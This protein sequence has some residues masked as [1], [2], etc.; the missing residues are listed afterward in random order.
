[1]ATSLPVSQSNAAQP[2]TVGR[3]IAGLSDYYKMWINIRPQDAAQD[4][5]NPGSS[6]GSI[7][8]YGY[9]P[10]NFSID[11]SADWQNTFGG[12]N[13]GDISK[14][15]QVGLDVTG[16]NFQLRSMTRLSYSGPEHLSLQLPFIFVAETNAYQDVS[17][18]IQTLQ[19]MCAPRQIGDVLIPPGP[20]RINLS[21]KLSGETISVKIGGFLYLSNV[22]I[23]S[24]S[25]A[26]DTRFDSGGNCIFARVDVGIR[27]LYAVSRDDITAM[28]LSKD[29]GA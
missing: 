6:N 5:T 19:Y 21:P 22:V 15:L 20:A 13:T 25:T 28:L 29:P 4:M 18:P 8:I 10:P 16:L 24:V 27:T 3:S 9:I 12:G 11:L 23:T 17:L 14:A 2:M 26:Y 7:T 1:M